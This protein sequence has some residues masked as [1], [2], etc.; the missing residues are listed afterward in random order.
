MLNRIRV[1]GEKHLFRDSNS[2]ALINTNHNEYND[3]INQENDKKRMT[4][5][6]QELQTIKSLLQ[7]ILSKEHNK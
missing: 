5:I 6:E 7:E 2:N 4:N 3:I 1:D